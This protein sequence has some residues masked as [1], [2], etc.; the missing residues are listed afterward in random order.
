MHELAAKSLSLPVNIQTET[1]KFVRKYPNWNRP[2]SVWTW[3]NYGPCQTICTP[4]QVPVANSTSTRVEYI[5]DVPPQ[6]DQ[7]C[8][9]SPISLQ[10]CSP[11]HKEN[12]TESKRIIKK[13]KIKTQ[14]RK[15]YSKLYYSTQRKSYIFLFQHDLF[16][17]ASLTVSWRDKKKRKKK[18]S[19]D[20]NFT[21]IST[22]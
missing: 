21:K 10:T 22:M 9:P 8:T 11:L 13:N 12:P 6:T 20:S 1:A 17:K 15:T 3:W 7:Y 18:K 4:A 14:R 16:S 19:K 2:M 5:G